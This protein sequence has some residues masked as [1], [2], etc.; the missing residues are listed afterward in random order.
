MNIAET[1]CLTVG[2]AARF[3]GLSSSTLAKLR[4]R[5]DGPAYCKLGRRVVYRRSD[6]EDWLNRH[7]RRST[8]EPG[9]TSAGRPAQL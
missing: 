8:S 1:T 7:R 2:D 9:P 6:L 4:L 3:L 5:G